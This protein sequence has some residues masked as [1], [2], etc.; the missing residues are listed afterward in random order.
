MK[1]LRE[2]EVQVS[3]LWLALG[4]AVVTAIGRGFWL[5]RASLTWPTAEGVITR[6]DVDRQPDTNGG[7][8]FRATFSYEFRDPHC[9]RVWGTWNKNFSTEDD[10]REFAERELP[11]GKKVVVRFSPKDPPLNSLELDS[12]TYTGDRPLSLLS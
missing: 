6:I 12:W 1:H 3:L 10:A 8:Y 7:H 2:D 11:V 4:L 9:H 5:Y